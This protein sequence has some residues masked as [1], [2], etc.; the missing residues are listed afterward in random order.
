[1]NERWD[2]TSINFRHGGRVWAEGKVNE[3]ATFYFFL[4]KGK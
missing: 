4:P 2:L 1:M 3:G